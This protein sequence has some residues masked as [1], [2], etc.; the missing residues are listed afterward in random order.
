MGT[1]TQHKGNKSKIRDIM[2]SLKIIDRK[3]SGALPVE[4]Y[5]QRLA[6]LPYFK[7][8][9]VALKILQLEK[10]LRGIPTRTEVQS[11]VVLNRRPAGSGP[12]PASILSD[13]VISTLFPVVR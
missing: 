6:N 13:K 8:D 4:F 10:M 7:V 2:S 9:N 12:N 5:A 3:L 1:Y 11:I